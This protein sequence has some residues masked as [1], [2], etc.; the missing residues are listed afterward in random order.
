MPTPKIFSDILVYKAKFLVAFL[1]N[2]YLYYLW[3]VTGLLPNCYF[4]V[5]KKLQAN[6][7]SNYIL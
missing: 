3:T 2:N 5:L 4:S 6:F 7:T 1:K